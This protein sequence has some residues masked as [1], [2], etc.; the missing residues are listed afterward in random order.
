MSLYIVLSSLVQILLRAR[1]MSPGKLPPFPVLLCESHGSHSQWLLYS[2]CSFLV[3]P[4]RTV[5]ISVCAWPSQPCPS[6]VLTKEAW[7]PPETE[8][9]APSSPLLWVTQY[10]H[11]TCP[12]PHAQLTP[13]P[14]FFSALLPGGHGGLISSRFQASFLVFLGLFLANAMCFVLMQEVTSVRLWFYFLFYF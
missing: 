8:N 12:L 13:A 11:V 4:S 7:I 6:A 2:C 1:N 3:C 14:H 9:A 10:S 5:Y